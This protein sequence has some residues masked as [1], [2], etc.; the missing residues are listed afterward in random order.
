M[1][2]I[3]GLLTL[4][5]SRVQGADPFIAWAGTAIGAVLGILLI[6]DRTNF[7]FAGAALGTLFGLQFF[8]CYP[9]DGS[10]FIMPFV[11]AFFGSAIGW[12]VDCYSSR[13]T[14]RTI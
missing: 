11:G 6:L 10:N 3:A 5:A 9:C 12:L 14:S 4:H 8:T 7:E 1:A 13:L 2:L